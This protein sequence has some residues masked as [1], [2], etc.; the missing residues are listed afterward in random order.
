MF[1]IRQELDNFTQD[2]IA[3]VSRVEDAKGA[4]I[5]L[6]AMIED[7]NLMKVR[8]MKCCNGNCNQWRDCELNEPYTTMDNVF[9]VA[10]DFL[11][12]VGVIAV[13]LFFGLMSGGF[14]D[15]AAVQFPGNA[16]LQFFFG[17]AK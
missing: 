12:A 6:D 14:F 4:V 1:T 3:N 10:I 9:G 8:L 11:A 17:A 16:V 15:W 13:V 7:A 5:A 2:M